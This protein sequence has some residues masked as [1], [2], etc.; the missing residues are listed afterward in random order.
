MYADSRSSRQEPGRVLAERGTALDHRRCGTA[1]AG[2]IGSS[3][4]IERILSGTRG[5]SGS[6]SES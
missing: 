1:T 4:T 2:S 6:R 5:P 3:P